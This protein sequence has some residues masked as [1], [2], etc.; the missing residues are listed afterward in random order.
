MRAHK[1][2]FRI[3]EQMKIGILG[4][5]TVGT[6]IGTKLVTLGHNV[7]MRSRTANNPK[8]SEWIRANGRNSSQGTFADAAAYGEM[9]FNCTVGTASL[10]ALKMAANTI[11]G[12]KY[13]STSPTPSTSPKVSRP[14]WPSATQTPSPSRF[15][16]PFPRPRS[17]RL[18]T[19]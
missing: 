17:L 8:A 15:Y 9:V 5:G 13:S 19:L 6:T 18:S 12:A 11:F 3:S 10:K 2:L 4:T 14:H 16:A 1:S 7:K